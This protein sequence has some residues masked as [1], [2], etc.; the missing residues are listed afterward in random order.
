MRPFRRGSRT[1]RPPI[2]AQ[3][4]SWRALVEGRNGVRAQ[5]G[6]VV[7]VDQGALEAGPAEVCALDLRARSVVDRLTNVFA[8][9]SDVEVTGGRVEPQAPRVSEATDDNSGRTRPAV[10]GDDL[11]VDVIHPLGAH[12]VT[13]AV[14]AAVADREVEL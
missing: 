9:I 2:A 5:R 4:P 11:A 8:G 13:E 10:N 12:R 1:T 6:W 7:G 14:E 3:L